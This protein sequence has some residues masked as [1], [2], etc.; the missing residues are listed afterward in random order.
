MERKERT[1]G[2]TWWAT[3]AMEGSMKIA[4]VYN[5]LDAEILVR[6][7][8]KALEVYRF[9][10]IHWLMEALREGGFEVEAFEGDANLVDRLG[11]FMN[12]DRHPEWPGLVL[13]L[14]YGVQGRARYVHVPG[15]LEMAGAPYVC[16]GPLSGMTR[17]SGALVAR[18]STIGRIDPTIPISTPRSPGRGWSTETTRRR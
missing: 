13:N 15:P 1:G 11:A 14:A 9:E 7:G 8:R 4:L 5:L 17:A 2:G 6:R 12:A 10:S 3:A 18:L 16:S